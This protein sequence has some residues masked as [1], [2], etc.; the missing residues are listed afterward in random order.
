VAA[1]LSLLVPAS[2]LAAPALVRLRVEGLTSTIFEGS[3]TS[4]AKIVTTA[5]G[6]S[7]QC[8]TTGPT[9]TT[10]LDDGAIA[11]GFSWDGTYSSSFGDFFVSR[12]GPDANDDTNF[13]Y[14]GFGVNFQDG[15]AGGCQTTVGAGDEVLWAYDYFSKAHL[16][17]LNGPAVANV[18]DPVNV[19]VTDGRAGG[20]AVSG[21]AV[22]GADVNNGASDANGQVTVRFTSTG[23]RRIKASKSDSVRSN[24]LTICVHNGSDGTCGTTAPAP[25]PTP[26]PTPNPTPTPAPN[27]TPTLAPGSGPI[28]QPIAPVAID[29]PA[30]VFTTMEAGERF[31]AARAPRVLRGTVDPGSASIRNV[32]IVLVRRRGA[33]CDGLTADGTFRRL[34]A[35]SRAPAVLTFPKTRFGFRLADRL[36]AGRYTIQA[37]ARAADGGAARTSLRFFVLS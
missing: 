10:V 28:T 34:A 18:N 20:T 22:S 27:P 21:A 2:A 11:G 35:C 36:G 37:I 6:G 16:L 29:P 33:V 15:Q 23:L 24:A 12:V 13:R 1:F 7:H 25:S 9:A 30:V 31:A 19:F 26:T 4:N 32:E 17:K 8:G 14:W 3:V 5:A